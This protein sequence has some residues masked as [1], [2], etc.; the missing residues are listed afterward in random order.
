MLTTGQLTMS[1]YQIADVVGSRPD[2]VK[3][4]MER[5]QEKGVIKLTP[6]V[7]VNHLGQHVNEYHVDK[8]NSYIVVAQLSPEFTAVLVDRWQELEDGLKPL[9]PQTFSEALQLAADQAKLIEEAKPKVEFH[10]TVTQSEHTYKYQEAGKKI[11]QRPNKFVAWLRENGYIDKQN[12]PY[13]RYLDQKLFKFHTGVN[14]HG[15]EYTQGRV[16]TKG[17]SYFTNKLVGVAL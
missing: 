12:N 3:R 17:L 5:L 4:T 11:Q 14:E 16:T 2:S 6:S 7:G 1:H 9:L 8:R 13:Q 10:D 15:H